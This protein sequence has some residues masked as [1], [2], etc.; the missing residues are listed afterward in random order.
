[1]KLGTMLIRDRVITLDQLEAALRAQ[2]LFG[3]KLGSNLVELGYLSVDV[4]ADYL[5]RS[6]GIPVATRARFEKSDPEARA[7]LTPD[8]ARILVAFPLAFENGRLAV[9]L[10]NPSDLQVLQAL[11]RAVGMPLTPYV[12]PET[13]IEEFQEKHYGLERKART[14]IAPTRKAPPPPPKPRKRPGGPVAP[15]AGL[16]TSFGETLALLETATEKEQIADAVLRFAHGR[17]ETA[18][19]FLVRHDEALWWKGFGPGVDPVALEGMAISLWTPSCLSIAFGSHAPW[20]GKPEWVHDPLWALLRVEPPEDAFVAPISIGHY[21]ANLLYGH[22]PGRAQLDDGI[23]DAIA[24]V[25]EAAGEAYT[26]LMQ[27][28]R[29]GVT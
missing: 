27:V 18:L 26:R 10:G 8:V 17:I 9:A 25:C 19:L 4:L 24:A 28:A 14:R 15:P 23:I 21:V 29:A 12:A 16:E 2:V 11:S 6:L 20:R 22:A 3:G 1:M 7:K 13:W 5:G